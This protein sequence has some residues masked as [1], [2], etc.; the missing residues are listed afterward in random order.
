VLTDIL[1][2]VRMVGSFVTVDVLPDVF[3]SGLEFRASDTRQW[4]GFSADNQFRNRLT[5]LDSNVTIT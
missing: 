4:L 3:G 1:L 2:N 5:G